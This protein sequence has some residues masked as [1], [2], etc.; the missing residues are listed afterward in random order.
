MSES[1][2]LRAEIARAIAKLAQDRSLPGSIFVWCGWIWY[3]PTAS[4]LCRARVF[5]GCRQD[6]GVYRMD[7]LFCFAARRAAVAGT[8]VLAAWS[9]TLIET[10]RVCAMDNPV[11]SETST[12][13]GATAQEPTQN[14]ETNEGAPPKNVA[15]A[16]KSRSTVEP[17][18]HSSVSLAQ[19]VTDWMK[20]PRRVTARLAIHGVV[21]EIELEAVIPAAQQRICANGKCYEVDEKNVEGKPCDEPPSSSIN[22]KAENQKAEEEQISEAPAAPPIP[23]SFPFA[24]QD[25]GSD[26]AVLELQIH[27]APYP[28]GYIAQEHAMQEYS[29]DDWAPAENNFFG[30]LGDVQVSVPAS[31]LVAY[32]VAHAENSVR[33]EM[34]EQLAAERAMYAQR[35]E[36]LLQHN[37]QLQSQLAILEARQQT[38]EALAMRTS[39]RQM[40][41]SP[42]AVK[43]VAESATSG[44]PIE[45]KRCQSLTAS[46]ED[47]DSIQEDLSNIR[48]QIAILKKSNPIPFGPSYVGAQPPKQSGSFRTARTVPYT[49]VFPST[50]KSPKVTNPR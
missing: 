47:W 25:P 45:Q 1:T 41:S 2:L 50:G 8:I 14:D 28:Q 27:R 9:S 10:D 42:V 18:Q 35:Y 36:L 15:E 40:A 30:S 34:T 20:N 39:D 19:W 17:S 26:S 7:A 12:R 31:T 48:H 23:P 11:P 33:L 16:P 37:Q 49:P 29:S 38:T 22:L 6:L 13:K 46:K 24:S 5:V 32:M 21:P 4:G 44:D 43:P 3:N